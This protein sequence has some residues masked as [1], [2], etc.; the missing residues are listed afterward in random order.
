MSGYLNID[1][2]LLIAL[3]EYV[4][5]QRTRKGIG[6]REMAK[7]LGISGAYLSNL[8]AGKHAKANPLLLKKI[9]EVLEIDHL[10]LYK[11]V[12][13]TNKDLEDITKE[14]E[15]TDKLDSNK[16]IDKILDSLHQ[17]SEDEFEL[18]EKYIELLKKK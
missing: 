11:I 12:G 7:M 17:F 14:Q 1:H 9:A 4:R 5:S 3:G 8:E 2:N 10:K 6:L 16:K 13:Y 18:I 15:R